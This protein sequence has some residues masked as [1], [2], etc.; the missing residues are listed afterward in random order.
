MVKTDGEKLRHILQNLINNAIKF[1]E[2]GN[3]SVCARYI[4]DSMMLEFNVSDTG[5]GIPQEESAKIFEMFKQ[6]DSSD[7]RRHEGLG[8]GLFIVKKFTEM[9]GGSIDVKSEPGKGSCFTVT[10]PAEVTGWKDSHPDSRSHVL[11][12]PIPS[13]HSL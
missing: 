13:P 5:V 3:I 10:L 11:A 1:T 6:V 12:P 8:I 9:L 7:T 2:R 4:P